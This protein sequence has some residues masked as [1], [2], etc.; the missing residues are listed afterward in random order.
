MVLAQNLNGLNA[1]IVLHSCAL[2]ETGG[3]TKGLV[4]FQASDRMRANSHNRKSIDINDE[5]TAA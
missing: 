4:D 1:R 2:T 5:A 3:I